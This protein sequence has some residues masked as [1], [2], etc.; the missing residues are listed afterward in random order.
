VSL[1]LPA[2]EPS[3]VEGDAL[4]ALDAAFA[5][6]PP[7]AALGLRAVA[8]SPDTLHLHA[9]LSAN[10]NDKGTAFGGS[11]ASVM[12]LAAWGLVVSRLRFDG[13]TAEVF[14][15]DSRIRYLVPLVADLEA[16][17]QFAPDTD[18]EG[19]LR[20][21]VGRGK[22]RVSLLAEVHAPDGRVAATLEA[23]FAA[24]RPTG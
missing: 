3:S 24:L 6:M 12:T 13:L 23:R 17:A 16:H 4:A 18:W 8:V 22:G 15:A 14:V 5:A 9:P 1:P 11:L 20:C 21:L 10:V 7:A 19:F 2:N